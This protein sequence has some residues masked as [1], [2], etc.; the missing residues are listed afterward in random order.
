[1]THIQAWVESPVTIAVARALLHSLWQGAVV[2]FTLAIGLRFI[3]SS[4]I[5]YGVACVALSAIVFLFVGAVVLVAPQSMRSISSDDTAST[6]SRSG[7]RAETDGRLA[8]PNDS[9][10]RFLP[11]ITPVWLSGVLLFGAFR[12][13]GWAGLWRLRRRAV[14]DAPRVWLETLN[15]IRN[16]I[17]VARPVSLM[18]SA[19]TRVPVVIGH[20]RPVILMPVGL[21]AGLPANQ[22]E[23]ILMH[24]MAHIRRCD[25]LVNMLQTFV[26]SVMFYNPA[27]WW[28]SS[29][30]RTERENSCDDIV[31]ESTG[32][33][34][35]Y[36]S[37]LAALEEIRSDQREV[38]MA[39]AGG[40]LVNRVRRILRQ[41]EPRSSVLVPVLSVVVIISIAIVVAAHPLPQTP[42]SSALQRWVD[43]DV[44]YIITPAERVA[45]LVLPTD[46]EREAFIEQ[47][48]LRRD[49]TP[50]TSA[51]EF[52]DE[53]YSR[54]AYA[55]TNFASTLPGPGG[56]GW[57]SDRGR[58]YIMYGPPDEKESHSAGGTYLRPLQGGGV[59]TTTTFPSELW[60]YRYIQGI[61]RDVLLEFVD[62]NGNGVFHQSIDPASKSNL[63]NQR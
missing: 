36:A 13:V 31:V 15:R 60:R 59:V 56:V 50:G 53:H 20:L 35:L 34:P 10:E 25:Y 28:I 11:W 19:L 4:R 5:R 38:V 16:T 7:D 12:G 62:T 45:F 61:G 6:R 39:A 41:S 1:M 44:V 49:P 47:F 24:E 21:L 63:L 9:L 58:I 54:I 18:E 14:S 8:S 32:Q 55:N 17:R 33:R 2:A 27:V 40:N 48:W 51:N 37:A 46:A 42:L 23:L 26:E 22:V 52:K 30:I 57:R 3:N 43:E 29:V